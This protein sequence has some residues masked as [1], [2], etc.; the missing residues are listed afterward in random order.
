MIV[1]VKNVHQWV[2]IDG[3]E[4]LSHQILE[5]TTDICCQEN[6]LDFLKQT[7]RVIKEEN[8]PA[9]AEGVIPLFCE[10]WLWLKGKD[11]PQQVLANVPIYL[12][13]NEGKTIEKITL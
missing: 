10:L 13:N 4:R 1:K 2:F 8:T 3:V 7:D 5:K 12:L 6:V 11:Y 9:K